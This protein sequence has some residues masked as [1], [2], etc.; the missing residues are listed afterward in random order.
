VLQ[1]WQHQTLFTRAKATD[2]LD[3]YQ[4]WSYANPPTKLFLRI[5]QPL[6]LQGLNWHQNENNID[7]TA[8]GINK[9]SAGCKLLNL[10]H[11]NPSE[12]AFVFNDKNDLPLV[13]H[14]ELQQ[15]T[16]IKVGSYLPNT[17]AH[18]YAKTPFEVAKILSLLI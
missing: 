4:L 9:G 11:L 3:T 16:K 5:K 1:K 12:V 8:Y 2:K 6:I 17:K 14:P 10:L 15:I 18:Y 7:I 13:E